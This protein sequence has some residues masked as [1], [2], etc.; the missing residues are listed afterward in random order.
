MNEPHVNMK[1][2]PINMKEP[3]V[4]INEPP[5]D[6]KEWPVNIRGPPVNMKEPLLTWKNHCYHLIFMAI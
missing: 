3:S 6:M 1:K 2:L 4:N 5:I